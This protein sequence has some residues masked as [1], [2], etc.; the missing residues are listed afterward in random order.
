M[1]APKFNI[2]PAGTFD[3]LRRWL[4]KHHYTPAA[5]RTVLPPCSETGEIGVA[6]DGPGRTVLRVRMT[7]E[8]ASLLAAGLQETL[9]QLRTSSQSERSSD[10]PSV[11]GS[12][13]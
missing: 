5:Y 12:T 9:G 2:V 6:F 3:A 7:P 13:P 8:S 10:K 11:E 1:T 4:P